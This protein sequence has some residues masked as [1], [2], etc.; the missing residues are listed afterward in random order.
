MLDACAPK[1]K[2]VDVFCER[3]ALDGDQARA[4]LAAGIE[5]GLQ[6]RIAP[7]AGTYCLRVHFTVG[8]DLDVP[9]S[10]VVGSAFE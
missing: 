5:R 1:A 2:W 4:I 7:Y 3:G 8:P 9:R 6:P 10:E